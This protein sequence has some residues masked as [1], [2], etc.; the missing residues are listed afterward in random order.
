MKKYYQLMVARYTKGF[1]CNDVYIDE[2]SGIIHNRKQD[3]YS[4]MNAA[5][6]TFIKR[7]HQDYL[8]VKEMEN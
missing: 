1:G 6:K 4:E 2:Y 7:S 8:F 5:R 3:A